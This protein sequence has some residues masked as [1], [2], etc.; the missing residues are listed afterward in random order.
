MLKM[1]AE[2]TDRI[3]AGEVP[4]TPPRPQGVER[5]V[6]VTMWDWADPKAFLHDEI[7]TDKRNPRVNAN[8]PASRGAAI[9]PLPVSI[10]SDSPEGDTKSEAL[11]PSTSMA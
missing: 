6:V 3:A 10:S 2:W 1:L 8:G 4:P 9:P 7:S 5:N 11:P